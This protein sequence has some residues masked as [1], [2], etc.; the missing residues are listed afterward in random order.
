VTGQPGSDPARSSAFHF[1]GSGQRNPS[2][3][4]ARELHYEFECMAAILPAPTIFDIA[5]H[6]EESVHVW[7]IT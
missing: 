7:V 6:K 1:L 2:G 4:A 5:L 3:T